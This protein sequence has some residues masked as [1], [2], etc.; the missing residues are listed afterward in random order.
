M[1]PNRNNCKTVPVT[2]A[3]ESLVGETHASDSGALTVREN[4]VAPIFEK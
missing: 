3:P 4:S 1:F 2:L